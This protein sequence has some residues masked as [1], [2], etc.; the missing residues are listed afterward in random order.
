MRNPVLFELL[1]RII[2]YYQLLF[3]V[4]DGSKANQCKQ[5]WH[6]TCDYIA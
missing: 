1:L 5:R 2:Y 4:V 6:L 3:I